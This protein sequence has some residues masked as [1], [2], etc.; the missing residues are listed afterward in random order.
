MFLK[1]FGMRMSLRFGLSLCYLLLI[2]VIVVW[3]MIRLK[4]I[5]GGLVFMLISLKCYYLFY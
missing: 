1:E 3:Y 2:W 5:K 4:N